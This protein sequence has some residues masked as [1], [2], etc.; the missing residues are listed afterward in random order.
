L[1]PFPI[2]NP[3]YVIGQGARSVKAETLWAY[4]TGYRF[5]PTDNLSA[6]IAIF[7]ND[8]DDL[9]SN[10]RPM[11]A[12]D[13]RSVTVPFG[14]YLSG[15]TYG[16]ELVFDWKPE[17]WL[18]LQLN[19]TYLGMDLNAKKGSDDPASRAIPGANPQQQVSFR[20]Q[21]SPAKSVDL[22]FWLRY[23]DAVPMSGFPDNRFSIRVPSHVTL[24]SRLAWRPID[25]IELSVVGQ[26][27]LDARHPEAAQELYPPQTTE[28]PRSVY[29]QIN[30][31]F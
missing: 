18:R 15:N 6:D 23:V 24:D 30:A 28:V 13:F 14:N 16:A 17:T 31:H 22:D 8:Y 1:T 26:N 5:M 20:T 11:L 10:E 4:E 21:F 7:Y 27:L 29:M 12:P 25:E 3:I 9:R 2:A 19:Y